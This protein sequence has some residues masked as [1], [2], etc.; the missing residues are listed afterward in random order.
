MKCIAATLAA[1]LALACLAAP[2]TGAPPG[3]ALPPATPSVPLATIVQSDN[4]N[5]LLCTSAPENRRCLP[6]VAT[7]VMQ[8]ITVNQL[9]G[10]GGRQ[11]LLFQ[12]NPATRRKAA[13]LTG[14]IDTFL[15]RVALQEPRLMATPRDGGIV[16]PMDGIT[17][18]VDEVPLVVDGTVADCLSDGSGDDNSFASDIPSVRVPGTRFIPFIPIDPCIV[19]PNG[20]ACGREPSEIGGIPKPPG[21]KQPWVSQ[22]TSNAMPFMCSEGQVP[23]DDRT[24]DEKRMDAV[25][26][27]YAK[28][29]ARMQMCL[30]LAVFMDSEFLA[31]C[32]DE[33]LAMTAA[34][35][36]L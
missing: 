27:C 22:S 16:T 17:C 35:D 6:L 24:P 13:E 34:C 18:G 19:A 14:A 36:E 2:A 21:T 4:K 11:T 29:A 15:A 12:I 8:D 30:V 31:K 28:A 25:I 20:I 9:T 7:S 32:R 5:Y 3:I 33:A 26:A 1:S 10:K 23:E